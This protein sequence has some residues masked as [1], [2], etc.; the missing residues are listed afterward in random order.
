VPLM[1]NLG[2]KEG[3]TVKGDRFGGVWPANEAFFN[4]VRGRGGLVG[5]SVDPL[6]SHECG[7]QRYLAI[8]WLDACLAARLPAKA[9]DPLRP[10]PADRAW[11]APPTGT[12]AAAAAG[13]AGDALKAGWLPDEATAKLWE[14]YVADTK[15]PDTT[16]PPAPT[17]VRLTGNRLTWD[18]EADVESGLAKFV[19]E[20]D[21]KVLAEVAGKNPFGRPVFQGLQYSD[22][23][24]HPLA[25][26]AF[27]DATAEPGRRHVYRVI[28]VNT[29]GLSSRP[30]AE[31]AAG[32]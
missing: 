1:L 15:V 19:I 5:V 25:A 23:P 29:A 10:M 28:A 21:G 24:P 7:N 31:A 27:T 20:R 16:A 32:R 4:A 14:R 17:N 13:Y 11:L 22:T 30:S 8:P 3:V 2:T 18:A 26:P 12:A 6:T 9:G